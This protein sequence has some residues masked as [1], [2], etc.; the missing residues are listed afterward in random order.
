MSTQYVVELDN[1]F[2][3]CSGDRLE[4]VEDLRDIKG[5]RWFISDLP[6]AV[7]RTMTVESPVKYV[8]VMVR[9]HLQEAGEFDEPIKIIT[10]WKKKKG[11]NTTDI[12]FTALPSRLYYQYH[13]QAKDRQDNLLLFPLYSI[14]YG[15]L[16]RMRHSNPV[17]VVFQHG[18]FADLI[19]G[20]RKRVFYANRCMTLD[21][22]GEQISSLWEMV[23]SDIQYAAIFPVFGNEAEH[24]AC[25]NAKSNNRYSKK[26]DIGR[27]HRGPP[28]MIFLFTS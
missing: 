5:D 25:P 6:G 13:D 24:I 22:S 14:L 1:T 9:K 11:G 21:H 17:A 12:F 18:R 3:N 10:H 28:Q 19:I 27:L 7:S 20:R 26:Q 16:K 4:K 15:V 23:R 8:E 2:Y